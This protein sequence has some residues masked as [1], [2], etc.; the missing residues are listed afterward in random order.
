MSRAAEE[1]EGDVCTL[2]RRHRRTSSSRIPSQVC[3]QW[4]LLLFLSLSLTLLS[5]A[6]AQTPPPPSSLDEESDGEKTQTANDILLQTAL[7]SASD[8]PLG[9]PSPL[10]GLEVLGA[11]MT[12]VR[13]SLADLVE[14]GYTLFE[15]SLPPNLQI[16]SNSSDVFLLYRHFIDSPYSLP[17]GAS[18]SSDVVG[19]QIFPYPF[20]NISTYSNSSFLEVTTLPSNPILVSFSNLTKNETAFLNST[21]CTAFDTTGSLLFE[22]LPSNDSQTVVCKTLSLGDFAL[23]LSP[24]IQKG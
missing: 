19:L 12:A 13:L 7:E 9:T 6:A 2:K 10:P 15:F 4:T 8:L 3:W 21:L 18:L 16:S 5:P 14:S 17:T 23:S 20:G 24:Y 22:N 11:N 1:K